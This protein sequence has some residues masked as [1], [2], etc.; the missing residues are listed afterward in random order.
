ML[1]GR[2]GSVQRGDDSPSSLTSEQECDLTWKRSLPS[3]R[4]GI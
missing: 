1:S 2:M 3:R 4:H